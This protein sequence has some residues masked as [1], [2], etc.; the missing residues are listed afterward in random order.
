MHFKLIIIDRNYWMYIDMAKQMIYMLQK[1]GHTA[2]MSQY[3]E[4]QENSD[5]LTYI[6]LGTQY[7]H[8]YYIPNKS[9]VT[10]F[11]NYSVLQNLLTDDI[12]NNCTLWDYCQENI[13][14]IS[15]KYKNSSCHL[16]EMGY[17]PSLDHNTAYI[18]SDKDIDVLFLGNI[19]PRRQYILQPLTDMGINVICDYGKTGIERAS[20]IYRSKICASIYN[21]EVT[22]P[23]SSSRLTPLL[24]NNAFVITENCSNKIMNDKW[25]QYTISVNYKD[26][27]ETILDYLGK[28]AIRKELADGFYKS[29]KKTQPE[30]TPCF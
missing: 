27:H 1:L 15:D 25:S 18:E 9:I 26:L 22:H 19:M 12:I 30:I 14:I 8:N 28:P 4:I 20:L 17:T 24:C 5:A 21:N 13:N 23:I 7:G 11:D 6:F 10:N 3:Q 2:E 29:F 16:F